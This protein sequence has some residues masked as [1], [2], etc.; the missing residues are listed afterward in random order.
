MPYVLAADSDLLLDVGLKGGSSN[1]SSSSI[2]V[3]L[4]SVSR[5]VD[6]DCSLTCPSISPKTCALFSRSLTTLLSKSFVA[7]FYFVGSMNPAFAAMSSWGSNSGY[8]PGIP[9]VPNISLISDL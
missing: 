1:G 5:I 4:L 3:A 6:F 7:R 8:S 2:A 9:S